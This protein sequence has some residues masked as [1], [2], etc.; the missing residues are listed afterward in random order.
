MVTTKDAKNVFDFFTNLKNWEFGGSLKNI[1]K[2]KDGWWSCDSPFGKAKIRLRQNKKFGIL[3]HDFIS[4]GGEWTVSCRVT[5]NE[6]GSTVTWLFIRPELMPQ[7]Q[8]ENQLRNFDDE[9]L[10]WKKAIES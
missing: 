8:F 2:D 5:T 1:Q 10:G 9:I 6:S 7:K 4:S 3:D